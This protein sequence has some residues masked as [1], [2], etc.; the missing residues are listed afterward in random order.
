MLYLKN[1]ERSTRESYEGKVNA[2]NRYPMMKRPA[3]LEGKISLRSTAYLYYH[4]QRYRVCNRSV[5]TVSLL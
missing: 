4:Y 1:S 3:F 2:L 5:I